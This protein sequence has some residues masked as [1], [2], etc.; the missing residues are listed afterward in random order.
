MDTHRCSLACLYLQVVGSVRRQAGGSVVTRVEWRG[1]RRRLWGGRSCEGLW[2]RWALWG[3]RGSLTRTR[4]RTKPWAR[5]DISTPIDQHV[6][7]DSAPQSLHPP[8]LWSLPALQQWW[9]PETGPR[10][11]GWWRTTAGDRG[12]PRPGS[13]SHPCTHGSLLSPRHG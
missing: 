9:C 13:S 4:R 3:S 1:G 10:C 12:A 6:V 11:W 7:S 2:F 5:T 8:C